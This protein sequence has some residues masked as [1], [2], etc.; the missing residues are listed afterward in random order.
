MIKLYNSENVP[1]PQDGHIVIYRHTRDGL[2]YYKV[3]SG[4]SFLVQQHNGVYFIPL[5][6]IRFINYT[7]EQIEIAE[8]DNGTILRLSVHRT[9]AVAGGGGGMGSRGFS[10]YSGYSGA[11]GGGG[12]I[13]SGTFTRLASDGSGVQNVATTNEA[14]L[15]FFNTID[16]STIFYSNGIADLT[17]QSCV[18]GTTRAFPVVFPHDP[19]PDSFIS[20]SDQSTCILIQDGT[21]AFYIVTGNGYTGMLTAINPT[22]FDITFTVSGAGRDIT[23]QWHAITG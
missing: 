22:S 8:T 21:A 5:K 14:K 7:D 9:I 2:L 15:I 13:E 6:G 18:Y 23:V 17:T 19:I 11:G 12:N 4:K 3:K 1:I 16:S 20:L 10:G